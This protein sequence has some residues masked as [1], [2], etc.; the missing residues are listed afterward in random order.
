[1]TASLREELKL[2]TDLAQWQWLKPH[3]ERGA[4]ILVNTALELAETGSKIA[5]DD[6]VTVERWL[7][8]GLL[9]KPTADQI[10]EWDAAKNHQFRILIISPYILI[11]HCDANQA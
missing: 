11:Q 5:A 3:N 9:S 1:M 6:R 4:I 7:A 8:S 2:Q 10:N